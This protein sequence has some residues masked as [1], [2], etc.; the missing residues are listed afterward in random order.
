MFSV[1]ILFTSIILIFDV[2]NVSKILEEFLRK[3]FFIEDKKVYT[4]SGA[5]LNQWY[6]ALSNFVK[7]PILGN[8]PGYGVD[9]DAEGYLSVYLTMLSDVGL[10]AF[11]LFISFQ[12]ILLK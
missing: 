8:G 4:S 5:R 12:Q 9:E 6:R 2:G 10:V 1:I 7:R 11:T 3:I